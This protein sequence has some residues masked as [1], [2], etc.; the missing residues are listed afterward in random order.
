MK[1]CGVAK[2]LTKGQWGIHVLLQVVSYQLLKNNKKFSAEK[3]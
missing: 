2:Q 3:L 1:G